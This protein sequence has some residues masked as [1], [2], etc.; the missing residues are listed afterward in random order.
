MKSGDIGCLYISKEK[1]RADG[2]RLYSYVGV[3]VWSSL[4]QQLRF[5]RATSLCHGSGLISRVICLLFWQERVLGILSAGGQSVRPS[6]Q[7][8][9]S[10]TFVQLL[11]NIHF[12]FQFSSAAGCS[13]LAVFFIDINANVNSIVRHLKGERR[14]CWA[15]YKR[16]IYALTA[17]YLF[18]T[19]WLKKLRITLRIHCR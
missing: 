13:A 10:F 16:S 5:Q 7:L 19:G 4:I 12:C 18:E 8:T 6:I 14:A 15:K 9:A 17:I 2:R 11:E 3:I 1:W